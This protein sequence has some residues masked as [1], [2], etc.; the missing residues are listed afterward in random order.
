MNEEE[1]QEIIIEQKEAAVEPP[2]NRKPLYVGGAAAVLLLLTALI[3]WFSRSGDSGRAVP[4][5]RSVTFDQGSTGTDAEPVGEQ[6]ITIAADELEHAGI[7]IETV[8]E[9]MSSEAANGSST[10]VVQANAYAETPVFPLLGGIVRRVNVELGQNVQRGQPLA[11]VFSDELAAAQSRYLALQT[12]AQT[13]RQNYERTA[14]LVKIS[15]VSNAELDE[16]LAKLKIANAELAEHHQHHQRA[17]KLLAIGAVSREEYEDATTK[18]KTAEASVEE[19]KKRYDRAVQVAQ[20]NPVSRSEFEQAAVKRQ[21]A[22][23]ELAAAGQKLVLYGLSA[24]R[25]NAL[26]SPSQI[27]SEVSIPA[28]V[29]G[30]ITKRDANVGQVVDTS[31]E[32]MKVTNLSTVWVIAQVY[33]KDL[34]QLRAGSGASVTSDAFPGRLFRGR[35]TYIDPNIAPETRTAQARIELENPGQLLKLGMY[36][37][38]AFGSMGTAERTMPVIPA[39]AVQSVNNRQVVFTATDQPNVFAV[40]P[41]RLGAESDGKFAVLEGLNVG[42]RIV[43]DGSFMLRA[44]LLKRDPSHH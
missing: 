24:G 2:P 38:V 10:G 3:I 28:P 32:L 39:S 20:I 12:E 8:G 25:V 16:A 40:K 11:V 5:P 23:S 37:N 41:V 18:I 15:P 6:T 9:T 4:A 43:T 33:E 21:T 34:G 42:D 1:N 19:A 22:E 14:R 36:V 13:A 30:T 29:S 35:V 26:R 7:K 44:E 27:T 17:T 31:K